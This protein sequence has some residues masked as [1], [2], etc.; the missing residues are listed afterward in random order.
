[1]LFCGRFALV[2]AFFAFFSAI[3]QANTYTCQIEALTDG[4]WF[5]KEVS[6]VL[7]DDEGNGLLLGA[8]EGA[9]IP[10]KSYR[11]SSATYLM[12][13]TVNE[14]LRPNEP[15]H[16]MD[17]R[18]KRYRA[19]FNVKRLRMSLQVLGYNTLNSS[20]SRGTGDCILLDP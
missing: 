14:A 5:P 2:G 9:P 13:W 3:A 18:G 12:D 15:A 8:Q 16:D 6:F 7:Q 10:V 20:P 19:L 1:M 11:R 17:R 4:F